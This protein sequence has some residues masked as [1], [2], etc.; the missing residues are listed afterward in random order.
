LEGIEHAHRVRL[1]HAFGDL[2]GAEP[3]D[4]G[5]F[6][7]ASGGAADDGASEN[8]GDDASGQVLVD[9]GEAVGG[10]G[11]AGFF[12]DLPDE[13]VLNG[14]VEFKDPAGRLPMPVVLAAD[15]EDAVMVVNDGRQP[16]LPGRMYRLA[17][18]ATRASADHCSIRSR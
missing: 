18:S 13:A 10:D 9:A 15:G 4:L 11:E 1:V 6:L 17:R 7:G 12:E 5:G 3:S 2:L 16:R 14:L 8:E